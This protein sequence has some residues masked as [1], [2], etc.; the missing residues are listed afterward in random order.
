METLVFHVNT[1]CAHA[2][3]NSCKCHM[4]EFCKCCRAF[5]FNKRHIFPIFLEICP[6][7]H[8]LKEDDDNGRK[9]RRKKTLSTVTKYEK[10]LVGS[11]A[12]IL[13]AP[14]FQFCS[15]SWIDRNFYWKNKLKNGFS[16]RWWFLQVCRCEKT[17]CYERCLKM[18]QRDMKK[19]EIKKEKKREKDSPK[20]YSRKKVHF[21]LPQSIEL[22]IREQAHGKRW[23]WQKSK[24]HAKDK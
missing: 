2:I 17:F 20:C 1:T 3:W 6:E 13:F 12:R 14:L 5:K 23:W 15:S 22:C 8:I 19:M 4:W 24:L 18:Q 11:I 16:L 21:V 9:R 7:T 10:S